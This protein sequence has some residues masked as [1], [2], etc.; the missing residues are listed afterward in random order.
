M[1]WANITITA[2]YDEQRRLRGF[3]KVT[4]DMSERK[5]LEEVENA[6]RRMNVFIATLAHELR[7]PLASLFNATA[8]MER[9]PS[10]AGVIQANLGLLGRQLRHLGRLVDD[11]LDIGR[12]AA[13]KLDL[14]RSVLPI[15]EVIQAGIEG[16]RHAIEA[17][18]QT[19]TLPD[20]IPDFYVHGDLTRLAQVLQNL[21]LN[22]SKFSPDATTIALN[23]WS[24]R[25]TAHLEVS[26]QG[27]GIDPESLPSVFDLFVQGQPPGTTS[28]GGLGIGLSLCRSLVELHGGAI[29]AR[30]AGIGQGSTFTVKL[31]IENQMVPQHTVA[32]A[33]NTRI[34]K[35]LIVDDNRDAADSLSVLLQMS[36]HV[37][38]VAYDGAAALQRVM[39]FTPDVALL[40]LAMPD[41]DGFELMD[42]LRGSERLNN[43]RFLALTGFGQPDIKDQTAHARF[44]G[45]LVKPIDIDMLLQILE[46][47]S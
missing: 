16:S 26:D 22:A 4:R 17:K 33:S 32:M 1:F 29:T 23:C 40:D 24:D 2:V 7:N 11:L 30:S 36:G 44:T 31:P 37:V 15:A 25:N 45:H 28:A 12:I 14:R 47:A 19:L 46:G 9:A 20:S 38:Q 21:L 3:A 39:S 27:Q 5:R 13:G 35:V 8:I 43:T 42:R 34:Q 18:G 41:M 10:D 6:A